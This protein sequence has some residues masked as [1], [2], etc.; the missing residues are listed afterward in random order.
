M[1]FGYEN[2][3]RY[4]GHEGG[5]LM[6]WISAFMKDGPESA[7]PPREDTVTTGPSLNQEVGLGADYKTCNLIILDPAL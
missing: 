2:F 6:T 1:L 3:E 7:L 4:L 5:I